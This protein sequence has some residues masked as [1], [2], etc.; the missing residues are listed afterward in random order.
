MLAE[1][2][3]HRGLPLPASEPGAP[4]PGKPVRPLH[5]SRLRVL[6][7]LA[8]GGAYYLAALLGV[9]ASSMSEGIAIFWLP[10]GVLLAALL[11]VPRRD[12]AFHLA[13]AVI[14]E[15]A[16]DLP[17]FT[18]T[19]A[20]AFAA[21]NV[22]ECVLAARLLLRVADP[23]TLDRLQHVVQFGV[24]VLVVACGLAALGGAAVYTLSIETTTPF[25]TFWGIWWLGDGLGVLLLTPLLLGWL[26]R[27]LAK[28]EP[29]R[30][31]AFVLLAVTVLLATWVFFQT[32]AVAG[33]VP[34]RAFLL[35][36]LSFWAAARFGLRGA[37]TIGL[38]VAGVAITATLT[39]RGPFVTESASAGQTVLLLQQYLA[40]QMLPAVA[41]AALLQ[42][43]RDGNARLRERET[44]LR[45]TH[46]ALDGLARELEARVKARTDELQQAN[47]RLEALASV[48]P[49]TGIANRRH[50]F[51]LA[52]AEISRAKRQ[53]Q[54]LSVV[55]FDIDFF[56]AINDRY[57]HE[58]GD[59]TLVA[60]AAALAGHLRAGDIFARLGGEEFILMLP[61]QGID[62]AAATADR[63]RRLVADLPGEAGA[64]AATV[65][66]GVAALENEGDE[67]E[68]LLRRA[69]AGLYMAK[70]QGR[71]RIAVADAGSTA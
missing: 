65:S 24:R 55:M 21:V 26:Q 34:R 64:V 44:E 63:L 38:L 20:L 41:L 56:K 8:T 35:L 71:N 30:V 19:Q 7:P 13:A 4:P 46:E 33:G 31:E 23:F 29:H 36:P 14:A 66:G 9:A 39:G 53:R 15:V 22:F 16:A 43:L 32:S 70:R 54:P 27:P 67:I 6:L 49:L 40:V 68:D 17:T 37:M 51:D 50:F 11:L 47:R 61:G 62:D 60:L 10:N 5:A 18:L 58:A 1:P 69:D 57:G 3:S 2:A 59:K 12:W 45:A 28:P 42:E 52:R 48:D 25:W